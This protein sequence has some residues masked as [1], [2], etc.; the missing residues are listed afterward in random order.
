MKYLLDTCSYI[1]LITDSKNLSSK[2]REALISDN[3]TTYVSIISQI[4]MTAKSLKHGIRGIDR[5]I[6]NYFSNTRNDSGI[7][8]LN[9]TLEDV[10]KMSNLPKIHFDP[11]DRLLISQAIN[12]HMSIITPDK[13]F[14]K[15]PVS[16]VF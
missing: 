3:S 14:L 8:F 12:N 1:W 4:E 6:V 5:S 15:Y 11:F 13:K 16:V 9:L 2:A 10:D 7:E